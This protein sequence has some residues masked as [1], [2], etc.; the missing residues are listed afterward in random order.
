M[1]AQFDTSKAAMSQRLKE[2]FWYI[3]KNTEYVTQTL[4]AQKIK[5]PRSK[6]SAALNGNEKY[7][8]E[9]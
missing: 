6:F 4:F 8:T 9:G 3:R 7:M 1:E 2:V 5:E